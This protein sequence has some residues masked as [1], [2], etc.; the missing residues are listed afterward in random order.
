L[1]PAIDK[2]SPNQSRWDI[3]AF[4]FRCAI[5]VKLIQRII[6]VGMLHQRAVYSIGENGNE[7]K[8][9]TNERCDRSKPTCKNKGSFSENLSPLLYEDNKE[10]KLAVGIAK[11][12][13]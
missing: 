13:L 3:N 9:R 4:Y 7:W 5:N 12:M 1:S 11:H 6:I 10:T 8:V 2:I